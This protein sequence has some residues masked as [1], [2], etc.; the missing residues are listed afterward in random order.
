MDFKTRIKY[1]IPA[2]STWASFS[3]DAS[4][5]G[6]ISHMIFEFGTDVSGDI[7]VAKKPHQSTSFYPVA[8][9]TLTTKGTAVYHCHI[10]VCLGDEIYLGCE[11]ATACTI[12][13]TFT[14]EQSGIANTWE[15][16]TAGSYDASSS[17]SSSQSSDSSSSSSSNS[18]SYSSESSNSSSS[19]SSSVGHSSSSSSSSSSQSSESSGSS[20]STQ[21]SESTPSSATS[22]SSSLEGC[23]AGYNVSGATTTPAING[24]YEI[25]GAAYNSYPAYYNTNGYWMWKTATGYWA[26]SNDK[27]DPGSQFKSSTDAPCDCPT[28]DT[29]VDEAI[30]VDAGEGSS[31]SDSSSSSSTQSS[32]SSAS[33]ESSSSNSSSSSMDS[34]STS[35]S[36]SI[37]NT[38]S[39]E[40]SEG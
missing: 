31:S 26:I 8:T 35:S 22:S 20:E 17:S 5:N 7:S 18:S 37:G 21:S 3:I 27:G 10:P 12:W 39:S 32:A 14:Y 34:S 33:S 6:W 9:Q 36:E 38:S 24:S 40:S 23:Y 2:A 28:D 25:K 30:T 15:T 13:V 1:E 4:T 16:F 19:S 29:W 11:I